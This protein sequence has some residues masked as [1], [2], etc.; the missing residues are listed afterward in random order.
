MNA[1]AKYEAHG[2]RGSGRYSL[3]QAI[4]ESGST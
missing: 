2:F 4:G 3:A 1:I